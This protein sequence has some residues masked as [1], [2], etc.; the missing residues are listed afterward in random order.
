[1]DEETKKTQNPAG[2]VGKAGDDGEKKQQIWRE[3][4]PRPLLSLFFFSPS[5][6]RA[7]P[8]PMK[9]RVSLKSLGPLGA[10]LIASRIKYDGSFHE[11]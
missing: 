3:V 11:S 5:L 10:H 1:M 2:E 6:D 4:Q 9:I 7:S 8:R